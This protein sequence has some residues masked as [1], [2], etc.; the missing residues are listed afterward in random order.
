MYRMNKDYSILHCD[1]KPENVLIKNGE[2]FISDFGLSK[3]V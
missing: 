3:I 1:L 2:I